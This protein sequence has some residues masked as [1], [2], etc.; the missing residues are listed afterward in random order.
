VCVIYPR[1]EYSSR[2]RKV[3]EI[4]AAEVRPLGW[5]DRGVI[6]RSS[7]NRL[8]LTPTPC[9]MDGILPLRALHESSPPHLQLSHRGVRP[10]NDLWAS[11]FKFEVTSSVVH[12]DNYIWSRPLCSSQSLSA[13]Q[14]TTPSGKR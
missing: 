14:Q 5:L 13:C 1:F 7:A 6:C 8:C 10:H 9:K 11:A 12:L 4:A 3:G 2:K